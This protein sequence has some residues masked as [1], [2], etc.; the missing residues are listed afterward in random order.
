MAWAYY[1]QKPG[2]TYCKYLGVRDRAGSFFATAAT[3][4]QN[5]TLATTDFFVWRQ[6][7]VRRQNISVAGCCECVCVVE[8]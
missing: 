3:R 5:I 4:G 7:L 2:T 8:G 6:I 1:A